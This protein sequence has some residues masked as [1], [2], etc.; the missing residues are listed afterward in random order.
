M[1]STGQAVAVDVMG[2]DGGISSVIKGI[3]RALK[4]FPDEI[5][6]LVLV[7][8]EGE[9][10]K[11]VNGIKFRSNARNIEICHA[12]QSIDMT[13]KPMSALRNKKDSSMLKAI[14]LLKDG[15]VSGL[16]SCGNTGCLVA[17]GTLR[18][19]TMPG[20]DRPALA[21]VIP[22]PGNHFVLIDVG[23]NPS[24]STI[25]FVH[26]AAMGSLYYQTAVDSSKK[27]RV[28]LLTIGTEEGKGGEA[29]GEAHEMLKKINGEINYFGLIEGFQLFNDAVDVVVCDGFVGNI[30]LKTI[31]SLAGTINN[32]VKAEM[33]KNPLRMLGAILA[34]GAFRAMKRDLTADRYGGAPLLGL[35]GTVVKSHGSSS[36]EAVAHALRL[37]FGLSKIANER[38]LG[39]AI[40]R[41]NALI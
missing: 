32:Y 41:I 31:E 14:G 3:A 38:I 34:N 10:S 29:I 22:A 18:L 28:G 16:L 23:A 7:G 9:I 35:N 13:E 2:G 8:D 33:K 6:D 40:E 17:G 5:G 39:S 26:N 20:I 19:R 24:T 37:T 4:L 15:I 27:P 12:S 21:S 30:L 36:P 1:K 25:N 11:H